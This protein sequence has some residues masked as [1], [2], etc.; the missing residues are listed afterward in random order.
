MH[1]VTDKCVSEGVLHQ[2]ENHV[3]MKLLSN[4]W[5]KTSVSQSVSLSLSS[6]QIDFLLLSRGSSLNHTIK[7]CLIP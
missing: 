1:I 4:L 7:I 6:S 5:I 2:F 3:Y